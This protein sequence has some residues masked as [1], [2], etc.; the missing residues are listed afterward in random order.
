M[1][2][3]DEVW[4]R[5][6]LA[7]DT[8]LRCLYAAQ[9]YRQ[10]PACPVLVSG[11]KVDPDELGPAYAQVM[12]EFL[13]TQG[14]AAVDIIRED[15]SRTTY[16]NAVQ[17]AHELKQRGLGKIMLV[18]DAV[19][20]LRAAGCFRKQGFEVTAA[21]CH[22]RAKPFRFSLLSLVPN[23][24]AVRN[25]ERVWHEWAGAVWYWCWGRI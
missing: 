6:E 24:G 18:V 8:R 21:A 14:V 11:G 3:P 10:G 22:Y 1:L 25:N 23:A 4:D 20:M 12:A 2:P 17:S 7:D 15:K 16:E 13:Q 5:A 9:L 19:D